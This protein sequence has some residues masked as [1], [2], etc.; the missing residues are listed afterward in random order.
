MSAAAPYRII[1]RRGISSWGDM[2]IA[3]STKTGVK[4]SSNNNY[5]KDQNRLV[6]QWSRRFLLSQGRWLYTNVGA[7]Q[8]CIDEMAMISAGNLAVQ[9]DGEDT[10][11][12]AAAEI[13]L[14]E[15]DR[16]CDLRG[17]PYTMQVLQRL[18]VKSV[19]VDGDLFFLLTEGEG[20]Y[21][22]LQCIPAHRVR[23]DYYELT[24]GQFK[25]YFVR[26]GVILNEY[27]RPIGY[28]VFDDNSEFSF[29][30]IAQ[31][32]MVHCFIPKHV[33]Q[34]RG[35]SVIAA[36]MNNWQD[37]HDSQGFELEALKRAS[38]VAFTENNELGAPPS[39][40]RLLIPS[41]D[42]ATTG[43]SQPAV[44][45]QQMLGGET[46]YFPSRTG[47]KLEAVISDRPTLNQQAFASAVN[48]ESIN[49]MGWA[50]DFSL[51]PTKIGGAP[52][53]LVAEKLNRTL[54]LIRE[55]LL[56][57]FRR[58]VDPWR[59]AKAQKNGVLRESKDL[60]KWRYIGEADLTADAM[61]DAQVTQLELSKGLTSQQIECA[62][63]NVDWESAMD[64]R[65]AYAVAK[66]D[67]CKAA[68]IDPIEI[69]QLGTVTTQ[70]LND[71]N[72][73]ATQPKDPNAKP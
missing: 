64:Q 36:S 67:K 49:S 69:D 70:T 38:S 1:D 24:E 66:R 55:Q 25:G 35:Y 53:R 45:G 20:G 54:G 31:A 8:G 12:G 32:D 33:D 59:L 46:R 19:L 52:A 62:R 2:R 11:W 7:V 40:A 57:P 58:R 51:D 37:V 18:I 50:I 39:D 72:Q 56:F 13:W 21:P 16:I 10:Q 23:G 44:Y 47:S 15:H 6:G 68:G 42:D 41:S 34:L 5:D 63:R 9:F 17:H 43:I 29:R 22:L 73:V 4:R 14:G 28:R 71:P 3:D 65:I 61:Y 48:R 26:D 60:F 30:D 27:A